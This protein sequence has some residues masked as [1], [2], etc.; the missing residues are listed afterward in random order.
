MTVLEELDF[1]IDEATEILDTHNIEDAKKYRQ[2]VTYV[3][4]EIPY[5]DYLDENSEEVL[6][7]IRPVDYLKNVSLLKAKLIHHRAVLQEQ[8]AKLS[9][10]KFSSTGASQEDMQELNRLLE[11]LI[12]SKQSEKER[13]LSK[14]FHFLVDKG[15]DS[16]I[17]I[18][19]TIASGLIH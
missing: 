4:S 13:T 14:I 18:L 17:A 19:P 3:F 15:T 10:E 16:L 2:K 6:C 8:A 11:E 7:D 5:I 9:V 12:K 1:Y